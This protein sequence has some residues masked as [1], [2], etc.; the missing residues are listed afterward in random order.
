VVREAATNVIRHSDARC[1]R[2]RIL[3]NGDG[4]RVEISDDGG[5]S[6]RADGGGIQGMRA[7]IESLGGDLIID[8][9]GKQVT[10]SIPEPAE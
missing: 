8:D 4:T 5:G 7:R 2:I 3:R 6:I 9:N 10:A 1:C